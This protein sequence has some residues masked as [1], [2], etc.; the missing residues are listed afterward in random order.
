M[1]LFN[2]YTSVRRITLRIFQEISLD[3]T[4]IFCNK[5]IRY[6]TRDLNREQRESIK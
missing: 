4:V 2:H 6:F 1:I 3:T 5:T